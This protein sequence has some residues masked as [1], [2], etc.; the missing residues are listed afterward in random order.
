MSC[1]LASG[2][3]IAACKQGVAGIK[4]LWAGKYSDFKIGVTHD[5]T[6]EL[7]TVL[8]TATIF[9]FDLSRATGQAVENITPGDSNESVFW[10]QKISVQ[11]SALSQAKRNIMNSL[12][13]GRWVGFI[14]LAN[15]NIQMY[16]EGEGLDCV[17]GS[18]DT[19]KAKADFVGYKLEFT[20][21]EGSPASTLAA[22]TSIPFD[23]FETI[24][25]SG[26][27]ATA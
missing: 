9:K 22:Y 14:E 24:T 1:E 16:G 11:F 13:K 8:P 7:I 4:T 25:V 10:D 27:Q 19:G 2:V 5:G 17:G 20:G 15:G 3:G 6:T 21:Q 26:V 18:F 23:N 12:A